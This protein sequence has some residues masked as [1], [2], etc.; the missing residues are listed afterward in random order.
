MLYFVYGGFH[1]FDCAVGRII[2]DC[3]RRAFEF[4]PTHFLEEG[5]LSQIQYH[6]INNKLI[7]KSWEE[8]LLKEKEAIKNGKH[9]ETNE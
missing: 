8:K 5:A 4:T 1:A 2:R 3:F 7:Y 6:L 9:N